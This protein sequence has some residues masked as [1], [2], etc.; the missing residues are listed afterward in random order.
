MCTML[1][2]YIEA[3]TIC[4]S[5]NVRVP[6]RVEPEISAVTMSDL[7]LA[8][9]N[10]LDASFRLKNDTNKPILY[11]TVIIAFQG[12]KKAYE[13]AVVF[14]AAPDT[15]QPSDYLIPAERVDPLP[16]PILPGEE[17]FISGRSPY[18][19]DECPVYARVLMLDVHFVDGSDLRWT[20]SHW[21]TEPLLSDYPLY[22]SIPDA[23]AW[24]AR[25][26]VF[27]GKVNAKG[28]LDDVAPSPAVPSVPSNSVA[29]ALQRLTFAPRLDNGKPVDSNVILV[30]KFV[31]PDAEKAMMNSMEPATSK[32]VVF[33]TF[34]SPRDPSENNWRFDFGRGFG[35]TTTIVHREH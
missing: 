31:R 34:D 2:E 27:D 25:E 6:L 35:Y 32:P 21:W 5:T 14:E 22:L 1:S 15:K 7:A 26:Y 9:W 10:G 3:D 18:T 17:K 23:K 16:K 30:V 13:Q 8:A 19:P 29:E 33:V 28:R 24:T 4:E 20:S 12:S 11:L